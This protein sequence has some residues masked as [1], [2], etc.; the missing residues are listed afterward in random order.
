M[1][2]FDSENNERWWEFMLAWK[3]PH[4]GLTFGYDFVEPHEQA[5]ENEM[6]YYSILLYLGPLSL[7]YKAHE[8]GQRNQLLDKVSKIRKEN[9][10]MVLEDAYD[11][12]YSEIMKTK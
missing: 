7:I 1:I 8:Q 3:W 10:R 9:P 12:A 5:P 2:R 4:Q 11:K 6:T